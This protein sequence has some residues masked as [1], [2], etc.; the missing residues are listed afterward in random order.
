M[1]KINIYQ[2]MEFDP[3]SIKDIDRLEK[4]R[5]YKKVKEETLRIQF[6]IRKSIHDTQ[7]RGLPR[8]H[9]L[10]PQ[11]KIHYPSLPGFPP[12]W[13]TGKLAR[14]IKALTQIKKGTILTKLDY[15]SFLEHGTKIIKPRPYF[16]STIEK[17]FNSSQF[18]KSLKQLQ[19][20]IK[21][22]IE[23]RFLKSRA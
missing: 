4:K 1:L 13:E 7:S 16:F 20:A 15:A 9:K 22:S 12:N 18:N 6:L 14:S 10:Y 21:N 19:I 11:K 23:R 8:R 2:K 5:I 17:H 3:S